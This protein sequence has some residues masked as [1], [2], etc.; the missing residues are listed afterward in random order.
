MFVDNKCI[1]DGEKGDC[2]KDD[3]KGGEKNTMYIQITRVRS[4]DSKRNQRVQ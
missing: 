1:Y 4:E 3:Y 2:Q